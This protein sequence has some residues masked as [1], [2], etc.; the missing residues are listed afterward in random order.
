MEEYDDQKVNMDAIE[1]K[2]GLTL[3]PEARESIR[4]YIVTTGALINLARARQ[5]YLKDILE[6]KP[7]ADV[8]R[9][10]LGRVTYEVLKM[11]L[12]NGATLP[13]DG[14]GPEKN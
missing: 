12:E 2:Y 14:L 13:F 9:G 4:L 3:S 5:L 8:V 7:G 10:E 6:K 11:M 1:A